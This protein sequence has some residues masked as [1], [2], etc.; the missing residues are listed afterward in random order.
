MTFTSPEVRNPSRIEENA[1]V[2]DFPIAAEDLDAV[3]TLT[4]FGGSDLNPDEI[5]SKSEPFT[6]YN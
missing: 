5:N 1:H 3:K 4:Y 6:R 2:F